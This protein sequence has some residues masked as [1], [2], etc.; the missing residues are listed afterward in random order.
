MNFFT[1]T[2]DRYDAT[3]ETSLEDATGINDPT[4]YAMHSA[5]PLS[6]L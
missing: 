2:L 1:P 4:F 5:T 3:S 6:V